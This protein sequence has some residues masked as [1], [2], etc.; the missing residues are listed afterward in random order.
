M[1][2]LDTRARELLGTDLPLV[3]DAVTIE[4]LLS[5]RSGI[6]DYLDEDVIEDFT[7]FVLPV[8]VITLDSA[9]SYLGI[10]DGYPQKFPP[11]SDFS[12]CNGAF[13]ILALLA[14]RAA[15]EPFHDLVRRLVIE[16]A[17]LAR[18]AYLRSDALPGDAALGY[19]HAADHEDALRTNVLTLPV[20][21]G[22]DGGIL[23][24]AGDVVALLGAFD[25]GRIVSLQTRDEMMR[26]RTELPDDEGYGLGLRRWG[27]AVELRGGDAGASFGSVHVPGVFTWAVLSNTTDGAWPVVERLA[28]VLLGDRA[29]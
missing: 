10:L 18:T 12:Y 28:E 11:G 16:P 4:H 21:G 3:D 26:S 15:D 27:S 29:P 2:A 6:G 20:V 24:T 1:L 13:C 19:L 5:H 25:A 22:G 23:T 17:G 7:T 14:E 9:E 8:P